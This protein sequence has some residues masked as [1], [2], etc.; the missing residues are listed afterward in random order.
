MSCIGNGGLRRTRQPFFKSQIPSEAC[1][2][3]PRQ[4]CT[5]S[6]ERA[7]S[8]NG[9]TQPRSQKC[10][11]VNIP[12]SNFDPRIIGLTGSQDAIA[13][14]ATD[15]RARFEKVHADNGDYSM[16]HTAG[17]FLFRADGR[18]ANII[19]FHEDRRFAVPKIRRILA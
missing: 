1:N 4:R 9:N 7:G 11:S 10:G 3:R 13:R 6:A 14:A 19:D 2:R 17:V 18:F 8:D 5:Q 16:N 12:G 15:F